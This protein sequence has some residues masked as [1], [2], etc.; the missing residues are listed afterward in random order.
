MPRLNNAATENVKNLLINN[1][2]TVPEIASVCNVSLSTVYRIKANLFPNNPGSK[3][4]I[5]TKYIPDYKRIIKPSVITV[6]YTYGGIAFK[7]DTINKSLLLDTQNMLE[8]LNETYTLENIDE[9]KFLGEAIVGIASSMGA[10]MVTAP[11]NTY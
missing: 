2:L 9:L 10:L 4:G 7:I 3:E 5:I 11:K 6:H 1:D 8:K